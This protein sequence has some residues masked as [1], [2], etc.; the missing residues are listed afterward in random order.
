[1]VM[2]QFGHPHDSF[3]MTRNHIYGWGK[4]GGELY[5]GGAESRAFPSRSH[6]DTMTRFGVE[7]K[8]EVEREGATPGSVLR[9][10]RPLQLLPLDEPLTRSCADQYTSRSFPLEHFD[11]NWRPRLSNLLTTTSLIV[12]LTVLEKVLTRLSFWLFSVV[13]FILFVYT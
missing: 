12:E 13:R 11:L 5:S 3:S 4:G 1:M 10:P 2:P 7:V 6:R 8:V 9:R